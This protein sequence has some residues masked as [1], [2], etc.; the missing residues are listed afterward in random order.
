MLALIAVTAAAAAVTAPPIIVTASRL[1]ATDRAQIVG[2]DGILTAGSVAGA[3]A[4]QPALFIAQ[5]GGRSG[6]AAATL[7]G[8]DPNFTLVLFDGVPLNNASS[9]RGGAVNLN[10]INGFGI[11]SVRLLPASL[12]AVHGSG[13][14]AGVIAIDPAAPASD[15]RVDFQAHGIANPA[16][17]GL[18]AGLSGPVGGGW[19]ASLTGQIDDDGSPTPLTRF[20]ARTAVLRLVHDA[21]DRL[22]FR[23]N[24]ID[25]Q[26]FPDAS[27][28]A[29]AAVRRTPEQRR[30]REYL[31]AIRTRQGLGG[32]LRLDLNA[33]WLG[34]NE[35]IASPGVAG[36]AGNPAGLPAST[37]A[38]AYDRFLGQASITWLA[39]ATRLAA[40]IEGSAEEGSA[41][42]LLDFGFFTLPTS[43]RLSRNAW[44]GFAEL[45]HDT[46]ST[47]AS[48][49]LRVDRIGTLPARLSGRLAASTALGGGWQV[50]A[51]AGSSF[52]AASFYALANP[53]VGNPA[54]RPESGQ[55]ADARLVWQGDDTRLSVGAFVARYR[56]LIDFV[57]QPA[58]AL[59][60]RGRVAVD[61]LSAS[62]ARNWGPVSLDLAAQHIW[63]RDTAGG[64]GLL[65]R[66]RWRANAALRWQADSRL[67]LGFNAGH[68]G[69]RDDESVPTGRQ[70]LAPYFAVAAHSRWQANDRIS[71]MLAADN[72]LNGDWQDA[73]GFPNPPIRLRLMAS[74]QF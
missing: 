48:A 22:L 31:A 36:S 72:L 58:P 28:G 21:G 70:R 73:A 30:A 7:D 68:V 57:F 2:N 62:I 53:L 11:S 32:D 39:G 50:E 8:A 35:A 33:S 71:L 65:L 38:T 59:I 14:L 19:G 55:R 18:A 5:P 66:P 47:A 13:A 29:L 46:G 6:F 27:G 60:N 54:L 43:Y 9:S 41:K 52:K 49:A 45:A 1:L 63:P 4:G 3:L 15:F 67:S 24:D 44:A 10:E 42:G 56:D 12:S 34:R 64:P 37:D 17:H 61:G 20:V 26:G 74:G 40:G 69:A 51:S 23:F 25:S 16:G